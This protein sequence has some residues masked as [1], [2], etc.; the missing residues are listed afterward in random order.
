MDLITETL[1]TLREHKAPENII[2]LVE[3]LRAEP[4]AEQKVAAF[5]E[6]RRRSLAYLE[7]LARTAGYGDHDH[8]HYLYEDLMQKVLC[9]KIFDVI[10]FCTP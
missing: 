2:A 5:D 7:D 1:K 4:S 8:E 3:G 6:L 10:N 9:G